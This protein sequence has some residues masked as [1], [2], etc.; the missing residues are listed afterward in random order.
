MEQ[1][2]HVLIDV[3][4][5]R[6]V[7]PLIGPTV[8]EGPPGSVTDGVHMP[9]RRVMR[10]VLHKDNI[11]RTRD[12]RRDQA[13]QV[14]IRESNRS[15]IE[16][17]DLPGKPVEAVADV[18][19][20]QADSRLTAASEARFSVPLVVC[21]HQLQHRLTAMNVWDITRVRVT[22]MRITGRISCHG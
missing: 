21:V 11:E 4:S 14:L 5:P 13:R 20:T 16:C 1:V 17:P 18:L 6:E 15:V 19:V 22:M 2:E 3:T 9:V 8:K 10:C 7:M 12:V